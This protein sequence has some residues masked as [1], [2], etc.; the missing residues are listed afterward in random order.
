[1]N[2][3]QHYG[4]E[5]LCVVLFVCL[6]MCVW[7]SVHFVCRWGLHYVLI[8]S[9]NNHTLYCT[10]NNKYSNTTISSVMFLS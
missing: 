4:I 8:L 10:S 6:Y 3:I 1:M 7:V 9:N 5:Y 2:L